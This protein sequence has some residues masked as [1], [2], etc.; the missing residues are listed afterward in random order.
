MPMSDRLRALL[1]EPPAA[2]WL[3]PVLAVLFTAVAVVF[4]PGTWW[5][6]AILAVPVVLFAV[7]V[8]QPAILPVLGVVVPACVVVVLLGDALEPSLFLVSLLALVAGA[9]A[10][11]RWLAWAIV[12]LCIASPIVAALLVP[13]AHI[14]WPVWVLGIGF[15]AIIGLIIRRLERVTAEL[16]SARQEL[17]DRAVIDERRRIGRDVHDL[18]GHGLAAVMLHVT[19]ARH[20][21]HQD[22]AAADEAL[23]TAEEVGRDSMRELRRTVELLRS[24]TAQTDAPPPSL[25]KIKDLAQTYSAGGM[26]VEYTQ[27]GDLEAVAPTQALAAYRIAQQALA[28]ASQHAPQARTA[29]RLDVSERTIALDVDSEPRPGAALAAP[30]PNGHGLASMHERARVAGGE[31]SAGMRDGR[32]AVRCELPAFPERGA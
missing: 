9:W 32:W 14:L 16:A 11:R 19:G 15:P 20:V 18:V 8:V 30:R 1:H 12:T 26:L 24:E 22:P 17:A 28:N 31:L 7:W 2:R 13:E 21:L 23:R 5:E 29:V 27:S 10:P 25:R 6:C 4:S 3:V